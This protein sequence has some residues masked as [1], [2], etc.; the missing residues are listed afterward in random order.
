MN[1]ELELNAGYAY[2][3]EEL[4][5]DG[6]VLLEPD[7]LGTT[8]YLKRLNSQYDE[9]FN[10]DFLHGKKD[11]ARLSLNG[12]AFKKNPDKSDRRK[13]VFDLFSLDTLL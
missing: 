12:F 7:D 4:M 13:A 1:K 9:V 10:V 11:T 3:L 5:E 6:S 2:L 8:L